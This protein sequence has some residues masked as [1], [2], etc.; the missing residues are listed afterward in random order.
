MY[1]RIPW[2][3]VA[4]TLGSA[5]DDSRTS[6]IERQSLYIHLSEEYF[7][8]IFLGERETHILFTQTFLLSMK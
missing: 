4:G 2:E 5:E 1:P 6:E 3:L 8:E 7:E